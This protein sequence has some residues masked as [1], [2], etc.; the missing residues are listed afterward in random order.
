M[1]CLDAGDGRVLWRTN[2]SKV[3]PYGRGGFYSS[4]AIAFG[5]VYAARDDGTVY[6]F[7]E[8]TGR[9]AWSYPTGNYIYG[10]PAVARVPGTPPSV[11]IGSYD[12]R[13][14]AL[15]ARSGRRRWRFDVGGPV[16][17][18]AVV[19]GHTVYTSSFKT[20]ETVGIDVRSH[21][22]TFS[23]REAGYTPVVSDGR[24]LFVI[25]YFELVGLE[26]AGR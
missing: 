21:R 3:P 8:Q 14:Y 7:D 4:P 20:R 26:P 12:E 10:S 11:Y 24:R 5:R 23:L 1:F 6:A 22:R 17:G 9:V 18:T 16:P 2:T 13:L 25:G 15:D 19:I